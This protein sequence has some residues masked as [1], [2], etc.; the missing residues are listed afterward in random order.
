[1]RNAKVLVDRLDEERLVDQLHRHALEL[2]MDAAVRAAR[3]VF[4]KPNLTYPRFKPGVTTR[5]EFV[6][7]L[8]IALRRMNPDLAIVVGDGEGGYNSFPM[9]EALRSMGF[10]ELAARHPGVKVV[11]LSTVP[12]T[13][14]PFRTPQGTVNIDVPALLHDEVDF[15]ISCPLPKIHD[16][17]KVTLSY[18]NLW[19]CLPDT[20]RLQYTTHSPI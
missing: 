2:G 3:S 18:K 13:S 4:L 12:R 1:V 5:V 17:T 19:G 20:M 9:T 16:M 11:N 15:A 6:E 7:A 10:M 8:V 14:V